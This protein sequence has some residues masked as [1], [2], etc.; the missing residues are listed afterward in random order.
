MRPRIKDPVRVLALAQIAVAVLGVAGLI[1][2]VS[3]PRSLDP[4]QPLLSIGVLM[5]AAVLTRP[6]GHVVMGL[7][8]P[9]ASALLRDDA[10]TAGSE[11][12]LL[13]GVNTTGAIIGSLVIP[14][15]LMPTIGS[16]AIV[17]RAGVD[18][19]RARASGWRSGPTAPA[20]LAGAAA[21]SRRC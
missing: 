6:A 19:R 16:P 17:V 8:F 21:S 4:D 3:Q 15:V 11:S 5:G 13:L 12:G 7:A 2:V 20:A 1:L 9:T 10:G 14:F 18:E